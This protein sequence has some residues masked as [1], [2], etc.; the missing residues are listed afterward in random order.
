MRFSSRTCRRPRAGERPTSD[1]HQE[2]TASVPQ[3]GAPSAGGRHGVRSKDK[4][5]RHVALA[6]AD[7]RHMTAFVAVRGNRSLRCSK[8]LHRSR[9]AVVMNPKYRSGLRGNEAMR[10]RGQVVLWSAVLCA[11]TGMADTPRGP[12]FLLGSLMM[13]SAK[14]GTCR[15]TESLGNAN[16]GE[17]GFLVDV[18]PAETR[19]DI[20]AA[21]EYRLDEAVT[22]HFGRVIFGGDTISAQASCAVLAWQRITSIRC[23]ATPCDANSRIRTECRRRRSQTP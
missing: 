16:A 18:N 3:R 8:M 19:A 23:K 2:G 9:I 14:I 21:I 6:S 15:V 1:L 12:Q 11:G 7:F 5:L 17:V 10:R 13:G 4:A 22:C 20:L